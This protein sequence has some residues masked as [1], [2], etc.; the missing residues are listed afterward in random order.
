MHLIVRDRRDEAD[1]VVS[2]ALAHPGGH[3]LPAWSPGAH[4]DVT[5][6]DGVVRQYSL[7]SDPTDRTTWRLGVLREPA[8]RGGSEYVCTKLDVGDLVE[9]SEP[10]NHFDLV[11]AARYRFVAG[12][13][14]ITPILA[15]IAHARTAGAD[16]SLLYGGRTR[17]SMAFLDELAGYGDRVTVVPQDEHGLLPLADH[18][19]E[20]HPD[21]LIYA[22]GPEPLLTAVEHHSAHW[23]TGSLHLERFTPRVLGGGGPDEAFEVEFA[24]SGLTA[25]VPAEASILD[26]AEGLGLPVDFSCR[27]GTCGSCETPILGGRAEHRDSVLDEAER[28]ENTCLM[29]CVSRAERGYPTLRLEL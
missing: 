5:V 25:T 1:G 26:I 23:P 29:I 2:L 17:S 15:M 21:T 18:L 11:P 6:D 27:E 14:G 3:D 22:C 28:A 12:G 13:I 24:A 10:R 16:W 9:V 8:G 19:A 7:S 4:V 20:V